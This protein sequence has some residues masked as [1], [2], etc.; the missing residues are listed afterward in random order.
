M[1]SSP[2]VRWCCRRMLYGVHCTFQCMLSPGVRSPKGAR[3]RVCI[4]CVNVRA[5][6]SARSC[7]CAYVCARARMRLCTS[8]VG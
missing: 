3:E 4:M 8:A 7:G 2:A 1:S 5:R 6:V